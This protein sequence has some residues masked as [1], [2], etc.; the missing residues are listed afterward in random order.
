MS[1]TFDWLY[2]S[3][4]KV[5][6]TQELLERHLLRG[7]KVAR[8]VECLPSMQKARGLIPCTAETKRDTV[9]L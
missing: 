2:L 7:G 1:E 5:P 4:E 9:H 3:M 6:G 8:L